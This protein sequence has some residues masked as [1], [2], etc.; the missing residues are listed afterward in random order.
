MRKAFELLDISLLDRGIDIVLFVH[1]LAVLVVNRSGGGNALAREAIDRAE[2][3][4]GRQMDWRQLF[5]FEESPDRTARRI[6]FSGKCDTTTS[7]RIVGVYVH[8]ESVTTEEML[9]IKLVVAS[10]GDSLHSEA[11]SVGRALGLDGT[12]AIRQWIVDYNPEQ[13]IG[14]RVWDELSKQCELQA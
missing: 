1:P 3:L 13:E 7:E 12:T 9:H 8:A 4:L 2:D 14:Q 11:F 10:T 5:V 6:A